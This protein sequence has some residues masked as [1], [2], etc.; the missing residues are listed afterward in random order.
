MTR[1]EFLTHLADAMQRDEALSPD[2]QLDSIEEWD[3][4]AAISLLA[5]YDSLFQ[6]SLSGN[7]LKNC[8][9]VADLITLAQD[10]LED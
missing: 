3:S 10:K 8:K 2:M 7:T 4:L 5:L 1:Q 6:I 9:S